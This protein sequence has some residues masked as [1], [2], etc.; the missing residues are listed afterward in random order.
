MSVNKSVRAANKRYPR[1]RVLRIFLFSIFLYYLLVFP[2]LIVLFM[3][4]S[5]KMMQSA[6]QRIEQSSESKNDSKSL[7]IL[8]IDTN[9]K[10]GIQFN[11]VLPE[12]QT[13]K[14]ENKAGIREGEQAVNIA[15]SNTQNRF[16][17]IL[18]MIFQIVLLTSTILGYAI[19]VPFK[20]YFRKLRKGQVI[21]LKL[22]LF[23]K[24]Y[25]LITPYINSGILVFTFGI[26]HGYMAY[27]L[28]FTKD[29]SDPLTFKLFANFLLV[30]LV[31]SLLSILFVFF[32]QKHRVHI[33][34]IEHLYSAEELQ[35]RIFISRPGRIRFRLYLT[36]A[37]TTLLPLTIVILYL[38]L[39][40]T[41]IK[42]LGPVSGKGM[43]ILFGEYVDVFHLPESINADSSYG[44]LFYINA[45]DNLLMFFGIGSGIFISFIYILIFVNWT[46][47]GIIQ[48][49]KELLS[50]MKVSGEGNLDNFTMVRTNDEIGELSEGYN[51]MTNK[52]KDYISHISAMNTANARF[53]PRQFLEFLGKENLTDIELGDQVQKE[54]TILFSDIRHFTELSEGMTPKENFD[55]INHYLGY[56]EPV[57]GANNGFIDKYIGDA[58][59]A[60]FGDSVEDAIDAALDMRRAL[61]EFN[62]DRL[63][64]GQQHVDCGIGIHTG[65]LML[66]IVG[67]EGRM[68]GTVISDAVNL[69]SRLEG[70]TK[71]YKT[72]IIISEDT[73]L[74]IKD[75]T[76]YNYRFL[77][78]AKVKGKREATYLYEIIDGEAAPVRKLKLETLA[79]YNS[80][81]ELFKN[82]RY[83]QAVVAFNKVL[84][85]NPDDTAAQLYLH[86]C[87]EG[88]LRIMSENTGHTEFNEDA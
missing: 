78:V 40:L 36:S 44:N 25:I 17:A 33:K 15:G 48:P 74:K 79:L 11:I 75:P 38:M 31:A 54:M 80:G 73:L 77:D 18:T 63:S 61:A 68:D 86:R 70:L 85:A 28:L 52:L 87:S 42:E 56:M 84:L 67:G 58:I 72:S 1:Y 88:G 62:I 51:N 26:L 65:N 64:E 37:T 5:P 59:M 34:Y 35:K 43:H 6:K 76:R 49:V 12:K 22:K 3:K 16:N 39:S 32:W 69:A 29:L 46:T 23:C 24:K 60:L 50:N 27:I 55:F 66:G 57:I 10:T 14:Q 83:A 81:I 8:K 19:N 82:K 45:I 2:F 71:T 9:N 21:S 13:A 53:V 47:Q 30:S 4:N 7:P 41:T 20:R